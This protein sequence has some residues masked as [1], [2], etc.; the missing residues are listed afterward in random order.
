MSTLL[1][2]DT[3]ILLDFYRRFGQKDAL[4][5]LK[6][7]DENRDKIITSCQIQME[8]NKNRQKVIVDT[9]QALKGID[10]NAVKPPLFLSHS[11][12][13]T[14]LNRSTS[15]VMAQINRLKK[16][17]HAVLTNPSRN[18]PIFQVCQRL[19]RNKNDLNLKSNNKLVAEIGELAEKRFKRG[20]PP[21]KNTDDSIGDAFNWEWIINCAKRKNSDVVIAT[22]DSDYGIKIDKKLMINDWLLQ[23]F[24]ERVGIKHTLTLTESLTDGLKMAKVAVTKT[25]QKAEKAFLAFDAIV[26]S[27][28]ARMALAAG[29]PGMAIAAG[30]SEMAIGAA[31]PPIWE[32]FGRQALASHAAAAQLPR[33]GGAYADLRNSGI[34]WDDESNSYNF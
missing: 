23:E 26:A 22:R 3:N 2:V 34:S 32:L 28:M 17:A 33:I 14:G 6:R 12:A 19:F 16:T 27:G 24:K 4:S 31:L 7:I 29:L 21:R 11:Q 20:F 9:L 13:A 10:K 5:V 25:E 30:L 8:Y 15:D 18:D 1:F